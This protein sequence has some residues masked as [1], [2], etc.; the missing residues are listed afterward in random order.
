MQ[1]IFLEEVPEKYY[2]AKDELLA[3]SNEDMT[4]G[5][6][7]YKVSRYLSSIQDGHTTLC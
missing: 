7:Q 1:P 5:E 6:L 2:I 4:V 3:A